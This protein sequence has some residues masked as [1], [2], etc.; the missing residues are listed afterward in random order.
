MT[1]KVILLGNTGT[2][3]SSYLYRLTEGRPISDNTM[4]I[5][6]DFKAWTTDAGTKVYIWDTAGQENFRAIIRS[7]YRDAVGALIFYD[8]TDPGSF[9]ALDFWIGDLLK[10]GNCKMVIVGHK[11]DMSLL[12]DPDLSS[13]EKKYNVSLSYCRVS[14]KTGEGVKEAMTLLVQQCKEQPTS[15]GISL[16]QQHQHQHQHQHQQ[17]KRFFRC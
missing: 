12:P 17:R 1:L 5:G 10:A 11:A 14:S 13:L 16:H 15:G 4:T 3:K 2:G 6:V 7:Y 9:K 8:V